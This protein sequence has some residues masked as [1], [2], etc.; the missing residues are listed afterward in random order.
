M[1]M[2]QA[3]LCLDGIDL[4]R[5]LIT[6]FPLHLPGLWTSYLPAPGSC[7]H[8]VRVFS[9]WEEK[10]AHWLRDQGYTVVTIDEGVRKR[11]TGSQVRHLLASSGVW[12][13][14]VP[15]GT[16]SIIDELENAGTRR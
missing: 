14:L 16:Q 10:K 6:P 3:T 13:D 9:R 7:V 15:L 12:R 1:R 5:V 11:M 4:G 2:I 8:F